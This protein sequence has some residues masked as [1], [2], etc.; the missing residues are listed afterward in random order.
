MLL[1][2]VLGYIWSSQT[3]PT[4]NVP[5]LDNRFQLT[6]LKSL[7]AAHIDDTLVTSDVFTSLRVFGSLPVPTTADGKSDPFQ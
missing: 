7:Q 5:A 4:A 6:S 1:G 2:M 3:D